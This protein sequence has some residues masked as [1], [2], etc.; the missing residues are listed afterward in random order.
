MIPYAIQEGFSGFKRATFS[1][2]A[3]TSAMTV[4]LVLVGLFALIM[5]QA[6]DVSSWL[7]QRVGEVELFLADTSQDVAESLYR[8]AEATPGVAEVEYVSKEQA[9]QIFRDEFGDEAVVFF[10][11]AFLP[12]SIKV[13]VDQAYINTDSLN[14]MVA[15]FSSW[16]RV[17]EVV[18]NQ[19]LLVKVQSNLRLLTLIG[20]FLG[21][22]VLIAS[23]F[24]VANTIR[25]AIYARRLMIRTMKLIGAT[26]SFVRQPFIVEGII[27]GLIASAL[28][29]FII[30]VVQYAVVAF[31]PQM[32]SLNAATSLAFAGGMLLA[33]VLLGWVG[34][35][36]AVRRFLNNVSLN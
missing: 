16:N 9:E 34:S 26:D 7:K 12:A 18:Y 27:Q 33:G 14:I 2:V 20:L 3:A 11:D 13:R 36:N 15:E 31:I 32:E 22:L 4:A 25:L 8:R 21:L 30:W 29:L 17:D 28:A 5:W 23:V 19:P 10:D 24:L 1:S 35:V 6:Q